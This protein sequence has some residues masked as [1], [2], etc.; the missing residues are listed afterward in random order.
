MR[1]PSKVID[2]CISAY[3]LCILCLYPEAKHSSILRTHTLSTALL[4]ET[5]DEG[6]TCLRQL[7]AERNTMRALYKEMQGERIR[8]R[9][10]PH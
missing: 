8:T 6:H 2:Y 7:I 3:P 5:M 1:T 9:C 10:K 4:K